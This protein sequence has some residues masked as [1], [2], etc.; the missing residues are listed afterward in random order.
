M[1]MEERRWPKI[2][3]REEKD[4]RNQRNMGKIAMWKHCEKKEQG[5]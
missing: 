4:K 2:G 5:I 3:L 1:E